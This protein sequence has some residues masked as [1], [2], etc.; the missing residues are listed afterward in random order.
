MHASRT[1][2]FFAEQECNLA[3]ILAN[4]VKCLK[5]L[6]IAMLTGRKN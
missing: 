3:L 6:L 2:I 1:R 4:C 5:L